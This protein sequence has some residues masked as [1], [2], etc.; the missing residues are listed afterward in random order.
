MGQ[1]SQTELTRPAYSLSLC[2]ALGLGSIS[3]ST[4]TIWVDETRSFIIIGVLDR[5]DMHMDL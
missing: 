2:N 1:G 3:L 4:P 5:K